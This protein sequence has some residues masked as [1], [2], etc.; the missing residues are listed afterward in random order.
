MALQSSGAISFSDLQTE[1]SDTGSISMSELYKD[2]GAIGVASS[3]LEVG[4]YGPSY[5]Y[6]FGV[7]GGAGGPGNQNYYW[8]VT[9]GTAS[10]VYANSSVGSGVTGTSY[11]AGGFQYVRGSFF[12]NDGSSN[13]Y[14]IARRTYANTTV[15]TD[16][17]TSGT[18]TLSDFYGGRAS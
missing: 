11:I 13:F 8:A 9:G 2:G 5:G 3:V 17:P 16:V 10:L 1:W 4:S 6:Y 14:L 15:N 12:Y 7:T 18:I